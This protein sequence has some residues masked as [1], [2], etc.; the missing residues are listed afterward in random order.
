MPTSAENVM[1]FMG[2]LG[3]SMATMEAVPAFVSRFVIDGMTYDLDFRAAPYQVLQGANQLGA[4]G[5][6]GGSGLSRTYPHVCMCVCACIRV[7]ACVG[8]DL[9]WA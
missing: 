8:L 5:F 1:T 9:S 2:C 7:C 6:N 3:E 4:F